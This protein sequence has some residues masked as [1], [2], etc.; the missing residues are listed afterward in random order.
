VSIG[1][2]SL[3]WRARKSVVRSLVPITNIVRRGLDAAICRRRTW[4]CV[5]HGHLLSILTLEML[6]TMRHE[7]KTQT[8][9]MLHSTAVCKRIDV[10]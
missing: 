4:S 5:I 7:R 6:N 2:L 10:F 3:V 8:D 9:S 1:V